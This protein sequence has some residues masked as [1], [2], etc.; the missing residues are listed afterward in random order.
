MGFILYTVENGSVAQQTFSDKS[1]F[2]FQDG[3]ILRIV[4]DHSTRRY[5]FYAPGHWIR[6]EEIPDK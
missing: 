3:G 5:I 6:V 1:G 2:S 4:L